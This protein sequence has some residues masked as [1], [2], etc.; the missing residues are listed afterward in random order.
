MVARMDVPGR[1]AG[2]FRA[3][4][5]H[6]VYLATGRGA[7]AGR[8]LRVPA[9]VLRERSNAWFPFGGHL[10]EGLYRT[11]RSHRVDGAAARVPGHPRHA[12]RRPRA[13]D[14]QPGGGR[15]PGGRRPR[16]GVRRRCSRRW[17][18]SPATRSRPR[19]SPRSTRCAASS[20]PGRRTA[21]PLARADR[22]E[23][24]S[25]W[26]ARHGVAREWAIAPPL[27]AAGVDLAWCERA[28]AVLEGPALEPGLE[29]VA[30]TFSAATPAGGGEGVDPA[31]L[32]AGRRGQ[33][34]LADGPRLAAADRRDGRPREHA[35]DARAQAPRRRRRCVREYG[36]DVPRIEAYAGELN[37]VWTNLID[38]AVDAMDGAGTL[39]LA[40]RADGDGVVVEIGDTGPG[41][42]PEVAARAFEA[43]YTTKDVG[44]GTGLGLDIA[45]RIVVERHG[46]AIAIDSRPGETVLRV[47]IPVR[48]T[49]TRELSSPRSPGH[50]YG[51]PAPATPRG[52]WASRWLLERGSG[53]G[54]SQLARGLRR[55]DAAPGGGRPGRRAA[56]VAADGRPRRPARG[57]DVRRD[58]RLPDRHGAQPAARDHDER[59]R[60]DLLPADRAGQGAELPGHLGVVRRRGARPS[61]PRAATRP[62]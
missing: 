27:A 42:P 17:A 5:E 50:G 51:I 56:V 23:A 46:G 13:R 22:E 10:I 25:S 37:Q 40:T 36:A 30:S 52:R 61:A 4:D 39:R 48:R 7:T 2:G 6:G 24:L 14:Q 62:R 55:Q 38:N 1:W 35:G 20:S 47:R 49:A 57:G 45:R 21:D 3:W 31:H 54:S 11:A 29:W 33:V 19:S 26:L 44:K 9:E 41:M 28:A 59:R 16:G 12:G 58:V 60:D 53:H 34:L 43:F 8:V 15:H 32:R 18:G